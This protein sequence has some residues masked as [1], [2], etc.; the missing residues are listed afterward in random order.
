MLDRADQ[1]ASNPCQND[2]LCIDGDYRYTCQCLSGFSGPNCQFRDPGTF[3]DRI[4]ETW[5]SCIIVVVV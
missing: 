4:G 3:L 5:R 1:C 2:G